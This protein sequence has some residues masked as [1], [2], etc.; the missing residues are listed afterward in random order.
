MEQEGF[1]L[2]SSDLSVQSPDASV[3]RTQTR[4]SREA[5]TVSHSHHTPARFTQFNQF[6]T[7]AIPENQSESTVVHLR[8]SSFPA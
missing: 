1:D 2:L 6:I 5:W 7:Q 4:S 8:H 3:A